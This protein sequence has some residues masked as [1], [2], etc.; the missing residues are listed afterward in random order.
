M[1]SCSPTV[2]VRLLRT[3]DVKESNCGRSFFMMTTLSNRRNF[4]RAG[5]AAAAATKLGLP[6]T[7]TNPTIPPFAAGGILTSGDTSILQFA[8]AMETI[9]ADIWSQVADMVA[10]NSSYGG[11]FNNMDPALPQ[12]IFDISRDENSHRDF[13]N[14]FLGY[15]QQ[16]GVS[17]SQ[18]YT[19]PTYANIGAAT[20]ANSPYSSYNGNLGLNST[21]VPGANSSSSSGSSSSGS[22]SSGSGSS[23][24]GSGS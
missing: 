18:F 19:M 21:I 24:S 2:T 23:G 1:R 17:L 14:A 4:L 7:T 11:A 5:L 9:A 13:L 12:Y 16:Q 20:K 22:S 10:T 8:A 3:C 6:Q 15:A